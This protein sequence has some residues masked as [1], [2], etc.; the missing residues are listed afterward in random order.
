MNRKMMTFL[1]VIVLLAAL[2]A[3]GKNGGKGQA[4]ERVT[5][6]VK[7]TP[8]ATPTGTGEAS[9]TPSD[10]PATPTEIPATPSGTPATPT[11]AEF[12][13]PERNCSID[14]P[15][16]E[17]YHYDMDLTLDTQADTI[18]GHVVFRF[19]N[20][21]ADAWDK[22]CLRDYPSL[23]TDPQAIGYL[24]SNVNGA[25]TIIENVKDGRDNSAL[26]VTR[27]SDVSV[28]WLALSKPL[29]PGESM[30]LEYDFT[31]KIPTLDDRFGKASGI[32]NVANFYPILAEYTKDGW[33]HV[34]YFLNGEC[35]YSEIANYD[36]KLTVPTGV[37]VGSTGAEKTRAEGD[38]TVTYTYNAPFVRDFVFS[39]SADFQVRTETH[40]GVRVNVL[41]TDQYANAVDLDEVA[42][43][44]Q[45]AAKNALAAF[46]QA[47]GR[48]PYEELDIILT[49]L[50]AGGMEY[51][52]LVQIGDSAYLYGAVDGVDGSAMYYDLQIVVAHEIGHQWFMGIVGSNSGVE[53]WQDESLAS[54]TEKVFADYCNSIGGDMRSPYG[55]DPGAD[56]FDFKN[57][58]MVDMQR[59]YGLLPINH[60]VHDYRSDSTYVYSI[61]YM[62]ALVME[63]LE[64][65]IG[66]ENFYAVIREYVH[67]NAFTNADP[68]S[69]LE[70]IYE[71][72]GTEN[73]TVNA[74]IDASFDLSNYDRSRLPR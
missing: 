46:G 28:I 8:T 7:A 48:Y 64:D 53:P 63:A 54:Y 36:V 35:F 31:T 50:S 40:E 74:I 3:C 16:R 9:P 17:V 34:A 70:L 25:T 56:L 58:I 73:A 61:Y 33:S 68:E 55:T 57:K 72:A 24:M 2:T 69:F 30:T 21:S 18:G 66:Q 23:F 15:T 45:I 41:Y 22:L 1:L 60:G 51:P 59:E 29:A 26:T 27:D 5:Q 10:A 67:R 39:A 6:A 38:G 12:K 32:Y 19:Y 52:N 49:P 4:E 20:D 14:F 13:A 71:C 37:I 11:P 43:Y 47:F 65:A 44:S 42:M 62:G